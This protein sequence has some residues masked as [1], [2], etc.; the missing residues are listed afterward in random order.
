MGGIGKY[1]TT[2]T[3]SVEVSD[4]YRGECVMTKTENNEGTIEEKRT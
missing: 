2:R 3:T 4:Y 1:S